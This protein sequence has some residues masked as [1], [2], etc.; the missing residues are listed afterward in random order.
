MRCL[1]NKTIFFFFVPS[2]A[3][4]CFLE[5]SFDGDSGEIERELG[6]RN[7]VCISLYDV[8]LDFILLDGFDDLEHPPPAVISVVNKSW[9]PVSMKE[10][11]V[12]SISFFYGLLAISMCGS[13]KM[14]PFNQT[15]PPVTWF[16][17]KGNHDSRS[18]C[19]SWPR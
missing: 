1:L 14:L 18:A 7:V 15:S 4:R 11:V 16:S 3:I 2:C 5:D 19:Y 9:L 6:R 13:E 10:K 17:L 12:S 8:L